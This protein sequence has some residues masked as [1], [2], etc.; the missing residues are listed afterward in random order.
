MAAVIRIQTLTSPFL[1]QKET[2]A[3]A[4]V[5][6]ALSI[7]EDHLL[8]NTYL[9]KEYITL[10][11]I[12]C[13]ANLVIG[14]KQVHRGIWFQGFSESVSGLYIHLTLHNAVL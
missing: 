2:A 14:F 1:E 9:V 10:A 7:L 8:E 3:I 13:W 11:D 4:A 6:S 12:I 5:K